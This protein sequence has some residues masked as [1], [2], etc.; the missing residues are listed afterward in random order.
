MKKFALILMAIILCIVATPLLVYW[1]GLS[2]LQSVP[3]VSK[4]QLDSKTEEKIWQQEFGTGKPRVKILNPYSYIYYVYWCTTE[5][6]PHSVKC[7]SKF[8]G[9]RIVALGI[10]NQIAPQVHG[11]GH[12][13]WHITWAS[14]SIWATRNWNI[15]QIIATYHEAKNT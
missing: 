5:T 8:P 15:H 12:T 9:I 2:N 1:W 3:V 6:V 4:L 11:M 14:Y 13:V 10:R 7:Q